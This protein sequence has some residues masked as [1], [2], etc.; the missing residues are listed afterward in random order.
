[1]S[2]NDFLL[3]LCVM[4]RWLSVVYAGLTGPCIGSFINVVVR[5]LLRQ[6]SILGR[7]RCARAVWA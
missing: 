4:P 2:V 7:S 5:R 6:E 1:M 3:G